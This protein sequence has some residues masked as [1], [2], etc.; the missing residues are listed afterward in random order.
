[1]EIP[2]CSKGR[3]A[4]IRISRASLASYGQLWTSSLTSLSCLVCEEEE[5][6]QLCRQVMA[7]AKA[8]VVLQ[9][10]GIHAADI[11]R[12]GLWIIAATQ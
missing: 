2:K 4:A 12:C 11:A 7:G 6:C 1:M 3:K 10:Q 5:Q 8:G 9:A